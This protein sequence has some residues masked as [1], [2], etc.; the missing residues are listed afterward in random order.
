MSKALGD[1][2]EISYTT[3]R[4]CFGGLLQGGS[5]RARLYAYVE[6]PDDGQYVVGWAEGRVLW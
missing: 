4:R 6:V 5:E 2:L 1:G 3:W